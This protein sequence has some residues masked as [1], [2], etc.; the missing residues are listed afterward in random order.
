MF[1]RVH[2]LGAIEAPPQ[3]ADAAVKGGG[4]GGLRWISVDPDN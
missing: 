4:V 2:I 1:P 3:K